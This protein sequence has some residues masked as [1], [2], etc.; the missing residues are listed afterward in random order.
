MKLRNKILFSLTLV[1][2][3]GFLL[4]TLGQTK[5]KTANAVGCVITDF[6]RWTDVNGQTQ[7]GTSV[8][9]QY[10]GVGKSLKAVANFQDCNLSGNNLIFERYSGGQTLGPVNI[11]P[12]NSASEQ[13][14]IDFTLQNPGDN[15]FLVKITSSQGNFE[16]GSPIIT[17]SRQTA[18]NLC[19]YTFNFDAEPKPKV[20]SVDQTITL[21]TLISQS[22]A[23]CPAN[24][25]KL[26]FTHKSNNGAQVGVVQVLTLSASQLREDTQG[27]FSN[28]PINVTTT[29]SALGY[30]V[31]QTIEFSG[32]L[33]VRY[34][35]SS[36][37]G[38]FNE[39]V[40]DIISTPV[41]I[42][43][44]VDPT[45]G[46]KYKCQNNACVEDPNGPL[47]SFE[48]CNTQCGGGGTGGGGGAGGGSGGNGG[49]GGGTGNQGVQGTNYNFELKP[50]IAIPSFVE[51][52]NAIGRW[53]FNLSIPIAV[54]III[55]A[56][57]KML[58]SQGEPAKVTKAKDM[59]RYA[60]WGLVVIFIGKGFISL[61]KSIL[62]L[63]SQ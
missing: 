13:H 51:L 47:A 39:L 49:G 27:K 9:A 44:V 60:I 5:T 45:Q 40:A 54:I 28:T 35:G 23:G 57:I 63:G 48:I 37:R 53:I 61:V 17:A 14:N 7:D 19:S 11:G 52:I 29:A 4:A 10:T 58:I 18:A 31:G 1:L 62:Q 2:V 33:V 41:N 32:R 59:L 16:K 42:G 25:V 26:N 56:G 50:P 43:V 30:S 24:D 3:A 20:T 38:S 55:Y 6:W 22:K 15:H 21:K 8:P 46:K 12:I 34:S 36:L